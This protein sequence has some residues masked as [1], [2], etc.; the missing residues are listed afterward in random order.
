MGM[1]VGDLILLAKSVQS[2][3][4]TPVDTDVAEL[5]ELVFDKSLALGERRWKME[6]AAFTRAMVDPTRITRPGSSWWPTR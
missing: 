2:D 4:V 5:T 1:L 6:S 3:F